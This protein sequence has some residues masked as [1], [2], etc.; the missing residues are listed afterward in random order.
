MADLPVRKVPGI[1]KINEQILS[2]LGIVKCK[3]VIEKAAEIFINFTE[4]AF[5]FLMKASH[6]L[7]KNT[8]DPNVSIKKSINISESIPLTSEYEVI[9]EKIE[10]LCK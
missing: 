4:N 6:G 1:G 3:D 9:K 8:H 10:S 2:G 7:A 5:D